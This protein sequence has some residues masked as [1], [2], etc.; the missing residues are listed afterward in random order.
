MK[1]SNEKALGVA[2]GITVFTFILCMFAYIAVF[3]VIYYDAEGNLATC[4]V[5]GT[6]YSADRQECQDAVN[7]K[8]K[9]NSKIQWIGTCNEE[10]I[11]NP[12]KNGDPE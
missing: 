7:G 2:F 3:D 5:H 12:D 11:C 10:G 1:N 4:D 6:I 8:W 9:R